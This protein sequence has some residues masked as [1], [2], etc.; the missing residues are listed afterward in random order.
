ALGHGTVGKAADYAALRERSR[1][2]RTRGEV[3][4]LGGA[5]SVEPAALGWESG[6]VR[7]E[8]TGAVTCITGASPHGQGHE[9]TFAQIVADYLGI[10]P[11]RITIRHGDTLG[12]PQAVGTSGSRS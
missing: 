2:R 12:A 3:V 8:K 6:A 11:D 9:T 1:E 7:V 5:R 4:G 10:D